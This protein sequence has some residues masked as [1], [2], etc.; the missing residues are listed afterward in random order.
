MIDRAS[1]AA[2]LRRLVDGLE[3]DIRDRASEAPEVDAH[4]RGAHERAR[5]ANRTARSFEEWRDEQVTLS[6]VSWVLACVFIRFAEDNGLIAAARLSGTRARLEE[7]R[8]RTTDHFRA[9]PS[10][11]HRDYLL[12]AFGEAAALPGMSD[13]FDAKHAS[14]HHLPLSVDGARELLD[15]WRRIDPE[16]GA[17]VCDFTDPDRSTRFLGDLYQDL[18]EAARKRYALLQTPRFVEELI[19]DR[20]L[21]P[22]I[23]E[24]GLAE[25][26][27]IDPACG[28]GHFLLGAFER[29]FDRW[30]ERE[31]ATD[32][33]PLAQRALGQIAGVDLNPYA[34][35]IARFRLLVAALNVCGIQRL[36]G[37]PNFQVRVAT[38]DALLHGNAGQLP[39][40]ERAAARPNVQHTFDVEDAELL[41]EL[42]QP[43]W[44]AVVANPPYIRPS[45]PAL[46]A[47]Y[48]DR[49]K[50]ARGAY[51]LSYPFAE[52]LIELARPRLNGNCP[53]F[54]GQITT[55]AFQ[56][57][58]SG[59]ALITDVLMTDDHDMTMIVDASG[60]Y[61]PGH[62]TPT[63]LLFSRTRAPS[64]SHIRGVLGI[65]GEPSTPRDPAEGKVWK[66]VLS[67]IDDAAFTGEFVSTEAVERPWLERHPWVLLGGGG[68][69]VFKQ[70][71]RA[72]AAQLG[73]RS[74]EI[75]RTT[76][77]G[78][79]PAFYVPPTSARTGA[80]TEDCV[81]L[82]TGDVV[83]DFAIDWDTVSV[84]PYD[85]NGDPRDDLGEATRRHYWRLR[86]V[87]R[88]RRDYGETIEARGH[89]WIDHSMFFPSRYRTRLSIAF[90]F[91]ATHNH[92]VLDRGG[93]VFNR[94]APVIKLP[95]DATEDD[96][97]ELLGPL[98]SS[99]GCFWMKQ[100]F[101]N[102]GSTV[103]TKGARQTTDA[104]E[105]F[106]E[107]DGTK[108]QRFPL[109]PDPPVELA[110]RLD[111]LGQQ[112]AKTLP[113]ALLKDSD[114]SEEPLGEGKSR[115]ISIRQ[116]MIALQEELDWACY[117]AYGL[118]DDDLTLGD[119][120]LPGVALG[121]RAF[122]IVLARKLAAGEL[123]TRW[124]ERHSSAPITELPDR[125]PDDYRG[126][127]ARR[128][129]AIERNRAM[130]LIERPEYK[131]RWTTEPWGARV[132]RAL[133]EWICE[134]LE[135]PEVWR[136]GALTTA[137]D[138]ADR[139]LTDPAIAEAISLYAGIDADPRRVIADLL[140][141][142]SVP[143]P[144]AR[145]FK[146]AGMRKRAVWERTWER[147]RCEDAG[148]PGDID[149]PPSYTKA[150]FRPGPAWRHRGK[151]D[152]PKERFIAYPEAGP[153]GRT[154][155]CW[156]GWDH[157]ERSQAVAQRIVAA[158]E[159]E[160]AGSDVLVPL[161]VALADLIPWV[162]QWHPGLDPSYGVE[163]GD[164][165]D[166][167]LEE[168]LQAI[169]R[170]REDLGRWRGE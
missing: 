96:H 163:L 128:I 125:W 46:T 4:L 160:G 78:A 145:R 17:L 159:A 15:Y 67:A 97:L 32:V 165:Y 90:A 100:V 1:L 51:L 10:H 69:E 58:E 89:R 115:W 146:E 106:Y 76:H 147:Q 109:P 3:A 75:G 88:G 54:V 13:L 168:R 38:G 118:T 9:H 11:S 117:R 140:A 98:N 30:R 45:D 48:R 124:F 64:S 56:K 133:R 169:G 94:S 33:R 12:W 57:R 123:E 104:F 53:G 21:E 73:T 34:T 99:T 31:P 70:V 2:D 27:L 63:V 150:D 113:S 110:R 80:T 22:A 141:E 138:L 142:E 91:V 6:A 18:S 24:F 102:K 47:S 167:F 7:A 55:N 44:A 130:R 8:Q 14:L 132:E 23:E 112:L 74:A 149:V 16:S 37:A 61:I 60:A 49:Y 129:E 79:D 136:D 77:T 153:V 95:P 122:E 84:F 119:T 158:H 139:V 66:E 121:E 93:K 164:F 83:R 126:L 87:L 135:A 143:A 105:N 162:R 161:L 108:L 65:R 103:D 52:L 26:T 155:Y 137:D 107:H 19:L 166:R 114:P 131:R 25:A 127:V 71:E 40:M 5:E 50:A 116:Q 39:G 156:A 35:A 59:N 28:S 111:K 68:I 144:P 92:F 36:R 85:D 101:H 81:P 43:G 86:T 41:R 20:T 148:E 42:L 152:V 120:D 134:R 29:L 170:V 72:G 151:L 62:G 82:V 154:V 157:A